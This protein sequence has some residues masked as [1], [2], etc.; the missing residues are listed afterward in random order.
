MGIENGRSPGEKE[1]ILGLSP[2]T[3]AFLNK[4]DFD[5]HT[6]EDLAMWTHLGNMVEERTHNPQ[7][8]TY[9]VSYLLD[10]EILKNAFDRELKPQ[11]KLLFLGWLFMVGAELKNDGLII[12]QEEIDGKIST[13]GIMNSELSVEERAQALG[14]F[15]QLIKDGANIWESDFDSKGAELRGRAQGSMQG[16]DLASEGLLQYMRR[17]IAL[18]SSPFTQFFL[19]RGRGPLSELDTQENREF[20]SKLSNS[21]LDDVDDDG[22][23][24]WVN[25]A[26]NFIDDLDKERVFPAHMKEVERLEFA[27]DLFL[28]GYEIGRENLKF[29]AR[30]IRDKVQELGIID[31]RSMSKE[32]KAKVTEKFNR[33]LEEGAKKSRRKRNNPYDEVLKGL[34]GE[35]DAL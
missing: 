14:R 19:N 17:E 7:W 35:L 16:I 34:S 8:R 32:K 3:R 13:S 27:E 23:S 21:L 20:F 2:L 30:N 1:K 12:L 26:I 6:E 11:K 10:N 24:N 15:N 28:M 25:S 29:V 33:F 22:N 31:F 5:T 4:P 18:Y 9:Y